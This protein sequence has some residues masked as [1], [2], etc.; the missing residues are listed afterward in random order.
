MIRLGALGDLVFCFQAFYEIRRAH[1]QA[2]IALLTR[3]PF[4][5][6]AS[7][8]PWFDRV[9]IDPHPG[10]GQPGAWLRFL[11]RIKNFAPTR[12]YDLQGK[13]RQTILY[14]LLG[15]CWGIDWSGAAPFCR[16]P[17]LWPPRP[18]MHFTDFLSAQLRAAQVPAAEKPDLSFLDAPVKKFSL[19][20]RYVVLVPGCSP[21]AP[22]KRWSPSCYA[23]LANKVQAHS[24]PCVL[25]GTQADAEAIATLKTE[26]SQIIDLAGQTSLPEL[27]SLLRH[28][29][30]V[31]GNDTGP[32]HLAAAI[33]TPVLAL[34]SGRSSPAWSKPPGEKVTVLQKESLAQ[35]SVEEVY[36]ALEA[37]GLILN[38]RDA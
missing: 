35:L 36:A 13:N 20:A 30:L 23:A 2:E 37:Q 18:G 5:S 16:F 22:H 15:A 3:A 12:V 7:L 9:I 29:C 26:A 27:A 17:R 11:Q 33:G 38:P 14:L 4:A 28:A 25:V 34:F 8:L 21:D 10:M 31:I 32:V 6:F 24:L 19:P 1:P